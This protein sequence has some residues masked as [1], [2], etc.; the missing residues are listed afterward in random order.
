MV[1]RQTMQRQEDGCRVCGRW[2]QKF[3]ILQIKNKS[4]LFLWR[5]S[6]V[7]MFYFDLYSS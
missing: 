6:V 4:V 3:K 7:D 5:N 1:L 2:K